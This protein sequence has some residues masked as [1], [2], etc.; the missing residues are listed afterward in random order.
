MDTL[1]TL[2]F[3][4]YAAVLAGGVVLGT[5]FGRNLGSESTALT[6]L[7]EARV[8]ALEGVLH[9]GALVVATKADPAAEAIKSHALATAKLATAIE[10][11][12]AASA[13]S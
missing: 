9:L 12:L 3:I 11:H 13:K 5:L 4:G 7:L 2:N 8:D 6:H 10:T 1:I